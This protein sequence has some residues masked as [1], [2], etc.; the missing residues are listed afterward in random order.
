ME[1]WSSHASLERQ[2]GDKFESIIN[3]ISKYL[4][5]LNSSEIVVPYKTLIWLAQSN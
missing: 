5:E 1:A 4:D 2:A 3:M